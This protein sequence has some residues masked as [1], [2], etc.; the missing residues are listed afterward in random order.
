MPETRKHRPAKTIFRLGLAIVIGFFLAAIAAAILEEQGATEITF[1]SWRMMGLHRF[2][3][4]LS[5]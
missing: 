4:F 5:G 2:S 1:G 3:R